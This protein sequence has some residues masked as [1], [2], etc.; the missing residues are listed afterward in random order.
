MTELAKKAVEEFG[1]RD[2][3]E[4]ARRLGVS[5]DF[6]RWPLVTVGECEACTIRV[7]LTALDRAPHRRGWFS[8]DGLARIIV[9][10]ELGHLLAARWG[11][12]DKR[13]DEGL[14][15]DFVRELLE[16]QFDPA[17]CERF[18]KR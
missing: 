13:A 3:Y 18:W 9:A 11:V 4:I 1:T 5:I 6:A 2:V 8:R 14:I 10:H 17:E 7:N 12:E 16:L 15:H